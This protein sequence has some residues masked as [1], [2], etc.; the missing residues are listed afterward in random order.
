[1]A[2][3][4]LMSSRCF[5]QNCPLYTDQDIIEEFNDKSLGAAYTMIS[6]NSWATGSKIKNFF[7]DAPTA[8]DATKQQDMTIATSEHAMGPY[9]PD[10][11]YGLL[12]HISEKSRFWRYFQVAIC[13]SQTP[14]IDTHT[15]R[16]CEGCWCG[17]S[18]TLV[19]GPG[20]GLINGPY[21]TCR[22]PIVAANKDYAWFTEKKNHILSLYKKV[23]PTVGTPYNEFDVNGMSKCDLAGAMFSPGTPK[24]PGSPDEKTLCN[25]LKQADPERKTWPLYRYT[26]DAAANTNK[27]EFD[28]ELPCSNQASPQNRSAPTR[29][30]EFLAI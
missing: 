8:F 21:P 20:D 25:F 24:A 5:C 22:Q 28:K 1:M 6:S 17:L 27:L 26:W 2:M 16:P 13:G 23:Y 3:L 14:G 4:L 10:G 11:Q 30:K 12:F 15:G 29:A 18:D 7:A 19:G 9:Q